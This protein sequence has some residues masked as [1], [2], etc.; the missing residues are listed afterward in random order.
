MALALLVLDMLVVCVVKMNNQIFVL[1]HDVYVQN[2][3]CSAEVHHHLH[4]LAGFDA[5]VVQ[6][7]PG[8]KAGELTV[9]Q[10][11]PF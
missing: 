8:N 2:P 7:T 6:F 3:G 11:I 1:L 5:Q 10:I 9:L 4:C